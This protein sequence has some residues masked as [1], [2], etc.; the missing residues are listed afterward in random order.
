MDLGLTIFGQLDCGWRRDIYRHDNISA[1]WGKGKG[2]R[3]KG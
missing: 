1:T 3:V 2:A